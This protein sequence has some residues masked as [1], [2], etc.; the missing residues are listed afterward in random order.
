LARGGGLGCLAGGA[1]AL[2]L[3]QLSRPC[4]DRN[5]AA[6]QFQQHRQQLRVAVWGQTTTTG[7]AQ[8]FCG[9]DRGERRNFPFW[10]QAV[11]A[12]RVPLASVFVLEEHCPPVAEIGAPTSM[13]PNRL[14][15]A[16]MSSSPF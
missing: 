7:F 8:Q 4:I 1:G 9:G 16:A 15:T 3:V 6:E 10:W 2:G 13:P 14:C 11:P 5:V 12:Q